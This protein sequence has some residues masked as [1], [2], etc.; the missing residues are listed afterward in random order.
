MPPFIKNPFKRSTHPE[1]AAPAVVREAVNAPTAAAVDEELL[2]PVPTGVETASGRSSVDVARIARGERLDR[3][4]SDTAI[5]GGKGPVPISESKKEQAFK[6]NTFQKD[7]GIYLPPSPP[8]ATRTTG[9]LSALRRKNPSTT[10]TSSRDRNESPTNL[11]PADEQFVIPRESLDGYRRSFDI[12]AS[13][14]VNVD[15]DSARDGRRGSGIR[16]SFE[17]FGG[18]TG[19]FSLDSARSATPVATARQPNVPPTLAEPV[20]ASN[21]H[22][23]Q[24][25]GT[26]SDEF[27]ELPLDDEPVTPAKK[28]T[29]LFGLGGRF[30]RE[31]RGRRGDH[32]EME[33][34]LGPAT[35]P[36]KEVEL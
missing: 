33:V 31:S 3:E 24:T 21:E 20:S 4:L 11:T 12:T 2:S 25:V 28:K 23:A 15:R 22:T 17:R 30:G 13:M 26:K 35:T 16:A 14:P 1:P 18:G 10:T 9:F 29:G 27:E 5:V 8:E 32:E 7:S 34:E 19:R 6:L 36:A